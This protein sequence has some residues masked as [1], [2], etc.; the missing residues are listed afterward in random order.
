[1]DASNAPRRTMLVGG[2]GAAE[3]GRLINHLTGLSLEDAFTIAVGLVSLFHVAALWIGARM[4]G[5]TVEQAAQAVAD[6]I[7]ADDDAQPET[8]PAVAPVAVTNTQGQ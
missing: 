4:G 1:M 7:K 5:A 6:A 3:I 2:L 8:T